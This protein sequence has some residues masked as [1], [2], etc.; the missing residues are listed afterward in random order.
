T[1]ATNNGYLVLLTRGIT[2]TS[3]KPVTADTDYVNIKAALPTCSAMTDNLLHTVCELTGGHLQLAQSVGV[4]PADVV[5][6][7]SFSTQS[8]SDTL[9]VVAKTAIPQPLTVRSTGLTTAQVN[10]LLSGHATIY[11]GTLSLPYYSSRTSPL[12]GY[13]Q[14][15]SSAADADSHLLTRFN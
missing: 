7:F 13:W 11:V 9:M 6:S 8:I 3:G 10:P 4:N 1:G 12:S 5:L 14:G 2:D 15:S